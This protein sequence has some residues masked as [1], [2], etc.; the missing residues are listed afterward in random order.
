MAANDP[1]P[2]TDRRRRFL[3]LRVAGLVL[4]GVLLVNAQRVLSAWTDRM[5]AFVSLLALI[6]VLLLLLD[7]A[8]ELAGPP[9]W[10]VVR[11]VGRS[12]GL[13]VVGDQEV[14]RFLEDHPRT[15]RFLRARL[16]LSRWTGWYLTATLVLAGAFVVEFFVL[17]VGLFRTSRL[18]ASDPYVLALLA[19]FRAPSLTRVLWAMTLLGGPTVI[20][21]SSAFV[22]LFLL[23]SGKRASAVLVTVSMS[24]GMTL[25]LL[26]KDVIRRPRPPMDTA[27]I[28][29][30]SSF[31]FPRATRSPASCSWACWPSCSCAPRGPFASGC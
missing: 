5:A 20:L 21:A 15:A 8:L 2:S 24:L 14:R 29:E 3:W 19:A 9:V 18:V 27:L 11:S 4:L 31:S 6:V 10:R 22:V 23:L 16:T 26:I 30:P 7:R 13:S 17:A 25:N 28:H 12:I 1:R